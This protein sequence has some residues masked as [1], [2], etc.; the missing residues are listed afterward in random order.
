MLNRILKR[1]ANGLFCPYC[2]LA[3]CREVETFGM[4]P[5]SNTKPWLFDHAVTPVNAAANASTACDAL[6]SDNPR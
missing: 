5:K 1:N 3:G 6:R 2:G 4:L